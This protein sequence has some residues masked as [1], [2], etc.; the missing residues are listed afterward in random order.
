MRFTWRAIYDDGSVLDQ[1]KLDGSENRYGNIDRLRLRQFQLVDTWENNKVHITLHLRPGM[2]LIH[3]RRNTIRMPLSVIIDPS[4]A[5]R[6][7][8]ETVWIVGW[9]ENR[10]GVNVQMLLFVFEDGSVEFM[11][12]WRED[13]VL[14]SPVRLLPEERL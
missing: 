8:R 5:S 11:D 1:F 2:K 6:A 3:R 9:H 14:Y 12:R 13:H 10:R 7:T 4:M